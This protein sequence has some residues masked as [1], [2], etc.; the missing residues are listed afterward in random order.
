[1]PER[2]PSRATDARPLPRCAFTA[3]ELLVVI[4]IITV[5]AAALIVAVQGLSQDAQEQAT[6]ATLAALES[7]CRRYFA[8]WRHFPPDTFAA[9]GGGVWPA[10]DLTPARHL[11]ADFTADWRATYE[12]AECLLLALG[13]RKLGGPFFEPK[14]DN[15]CDGDKDRLQDARFTYCE[16]ADGWG[17]PI[18]YQ[19]LGDQKGV[20]LTSAGKDMQ[21]G[22]PD[23]LAY[24]QTP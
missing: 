12:G 3:I 23:D 15:V 17:G 6:K 7:A 18:R 9:L 2:Q 8:A 16:F 19:N 4:L 21:F 1:M 14:H 11:Q 22:T 5:L 20:R 13:S 10:A 24:G